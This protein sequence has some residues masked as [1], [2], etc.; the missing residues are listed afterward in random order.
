MPVLQ[1]SHV[2][3]QISFKGDG[4]C[5]KYCTYTFMNQADKTIRVMKVVDK[6][7]TALKSGLKEARGFNNAIKSIIDAEVDLKEVVTYAHP[8]IAKIMS[9]LYL[10]R[11][12]E[13]CQ[14]V[15][16]FIYMYIIVLL[17]GCSQRR[18]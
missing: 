5:A 9:T 2:H 7:E 1:R 15:N 4:F 17:I 11:I 12:N 6:R 14:T 3:L 13:M 8:K 16:K 10:D 18:Y